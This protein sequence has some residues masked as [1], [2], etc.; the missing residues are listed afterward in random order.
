M[1]TDRKMRETVQPITEDFGVLTNQVWKQEKVFSRM[2]YKQA[3]KT[4]HSFRFR[5]L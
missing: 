5:L 2:R 1:E 4:S 3:S